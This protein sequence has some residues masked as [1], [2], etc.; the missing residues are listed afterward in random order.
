[1][2]KLFGGTLVVANSAN[3]LNLANFNLSISN[4]YIAYRWLF[5]KLAKLSSTKRQFG[6]LLLFMV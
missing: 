4:F 6:K 5:S 2:T 1:M 3:L